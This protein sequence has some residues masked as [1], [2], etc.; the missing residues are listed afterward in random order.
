MA[1]ASLQPMAVPV[2]GTYFHVITDAAGSGNVTDAQIAA[3][4]DV[5][6]KAYTGRFVFELLEVNRVRNDAWFY[7]YPGDTSESEAKTA[8]RKGTM[9]HLNLYTAD[10]SGGL[11]GWATFPSGMYG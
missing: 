2:I 11:L 7:M 8:L 6:N 4:M 3:Q 10:L 1:A 9:Q 5:L